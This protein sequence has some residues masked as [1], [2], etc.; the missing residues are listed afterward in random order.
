[1]SSGNRESG[2]SPEAEGVRIRPQPPTLDLT[3]TEVASDTPAG[4]Q[5]VDAS[6]TAAPTNCPIRLTALPRAGAG[7]RTGA[8]Y[9]ISP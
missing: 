6:E 8:R 3:A 2:N 7:R 1:M 4:E 5:H 9:A